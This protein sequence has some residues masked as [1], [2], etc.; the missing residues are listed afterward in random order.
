MV[1]RGVVEHDFDFAKTL[2]YGFEYQ[3]REV[4]GD[5]ARRREVIGPNDT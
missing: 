4:R 3:R 5:P 1:M 2:R